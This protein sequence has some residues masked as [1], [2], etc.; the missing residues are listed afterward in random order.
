MYMYPMWRTM[1]DAPAKNKIEVTGTGI[2][3]AAPDQAVVTLGA[4]SKDISLEEAQRKNN[5]AIQQ[6]I[7]A[8]IELGVSPEQIQTA[9]FRINPEYDFKDGEQI[10][11]GYQ[12]FH[13][14][15]ITLNDLALAGPV[16][17]TATASGA[18]IVRGIDFSLQN[19]DSYYNLALQSAIDQAEAKAMAIAQSL[20]VT[21]N[22]VP[23]SV[24]ENPSTRI[25]VPVYKS[26]VLSADASATPIE[27]GQL[28]IEANVLV[29]YHYFS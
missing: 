16:I 22:N 6:I 15:R 27:P 12:V 2:I 3:D 24:V 17:D 20:N 7:Q 4:E 18:N 9:D 14:L 29:T 28:K 19:Q 1:D 13:L 21:L 23:V 8:V 25:P 10:F 11:T 5:A 26:A